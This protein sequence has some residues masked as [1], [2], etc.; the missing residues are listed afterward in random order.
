MAS[1][2]EWVM[3]SLRSAT[4]GNENG[5][6]KESDIIDVPRAKEVGYGLAF[7]SRV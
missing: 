6:E 2:C 1:L 7:R 5:V 3:P 4:E